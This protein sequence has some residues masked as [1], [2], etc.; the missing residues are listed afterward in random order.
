[1]NKGEVGKLEAD[2]VESNLWELALLSAELTCCFLARSLRRVSFF[3][4]HFSYFAIQIFVYIKGLGEWNKNLINKLYFVPFWPHKN[5]IPNIILILLYF[6]FV[7]IL[8]AAM[9]MHEENPLHRHPFQLFSLLLFFSLNCLEADFAARI[10]IILQHPEIY[11]YV[12]IAAR[13]CIPKIQSACE[14][15]HYLSY[16]SSFILVLITS[17]ITL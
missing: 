5:S 4:Y 9:P 14:S 16:P 3:L 12:T 1:M 8:A 15:S 10:R 13:I 6:N 17:R 7:V 2:R 11:K